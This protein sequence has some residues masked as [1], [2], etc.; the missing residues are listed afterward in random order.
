MLF[1]SKY[2]MP[3]TKKRGRSAQHV[4][5]EP[6]QEARVS[7]DEQLGAWLEEDSGELVRC[8]RPPTMGSIEF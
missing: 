1:A 6:E 8:G 2:G 7:R 5:M 3:S 4:V